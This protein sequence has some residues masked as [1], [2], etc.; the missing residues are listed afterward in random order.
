VQAFT[1]LVRTNCTTRDAVIDAKE[2]SHG[3]VPILNSNLVVA[4]PL[5]VGKWTWLVTSEAAPGFLNSVGSLVLFS[6]RFLLKQLR[7]KLAV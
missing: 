2:F 7:L 6:L 5:E 1:G 3:L 4:H